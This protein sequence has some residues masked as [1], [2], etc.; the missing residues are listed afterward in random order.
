M[1]S[2]SPQ[3]GNDDHPLLAPTLRDFTDVFQEA[4]NLP[5]QSQLDHH[6]PSQHNAPPVKVWPYRYPH[7]QKGEVKRLV[8]E[9]LAAGI[10]QLS[11]SPFSSPILLVKKKDKTRRFCVDYRAL[12][13]IT[14]KDSFP[15]PTTD[16]LMDELQSAEIFSKL[17]LRAVHHQIHVSPAD[18][19]K[20]AFA[21]MR[22]IM[23]FL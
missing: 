23:S 7:F 15:I 11:T 16:E 1:P 2:E 21:P 5:P 3:P 14:I 18:V 4:T 12:N 13:N 8:T 19:P 17:D 20:T 10:I 6:I 22:V 9:M